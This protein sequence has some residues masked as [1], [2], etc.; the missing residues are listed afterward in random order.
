M[1]LLNQAKIAELLE[2]AAGNPRKRVNFNFHD[3]VNETVN[4]LC[5]AAL[6]GS[7]FA[8]Q[9]HPGKWELLCLVHGRVICR[10]YDDAGHAVEEITMEPGG[11]VM[12]EIP[13]GVWHNLEV[14]SPC[15]F[16]EVKLGPYVPVG[17]EDTLQL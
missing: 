14:L 2:A 13:A 16:Y 15:V 3:D 17:P 10:W 6:P 5:I 8:I 1:K 7:P 4:R 12:L 9:R 11:N